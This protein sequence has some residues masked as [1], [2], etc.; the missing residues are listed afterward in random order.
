M[1]IGD[2]RFDTPNLVP[3]EPAGRSEEGGA[4]E[5]NIVDA[6]AKVVAAHPDRLAVVDE[7]AS[8]R[9]DQLNDEAR[10][11]ARFVA[12]L[13]LPAETPVA[14]MI[15]RSWR[16]VAATLGVLMAGCA[17]VPLDP[18]MPLSRRR[19]IAAEAGAPLL[20]SETAQLRD[21][22]RLQWACPDL[23]HILCLDSD[24]LDG[25]SEPHG[26]L[27]SE[28]LWDHL[29]GGAE[30]DVLAGG[31][32]SAFTGQ[33]IPEAAMTAFGANARSKIAPL[34]GS[35][36]SVL[37]IGCASGFTLRAVAPMVTRYLATDL[38]RR[39]IERIV[40]EARRLDL[41][42]V[43]VRVL[44]AHDIDI[45]SDERFDLVIANS[46][47]ESF[48]GFGYLRDF[49]AKA[50]ALLKPGG[51]IFIGHVW[52][53][54]RRD[55]YQDDLAAFARANT[56]LGCQTRL[57]CSED[58][59]IP[60][61]FF[62]DWAAER[63]GI[64][65]IV[66]NMEIDGFDPAPY[67]FD[68]LLRLDP[69]AAQRPPRR[70]RHD[71][72][73]LAATP[74]T[75]LPSP[76][77]RSLAYVLFTSG[78][79]GI[80]KGVMI[81]H[82]S[83]VN[84][85][86]SVNASQFA[87]LGAPLSVACIASFAF[88]GSV[89]QI[90]AALLGGHSLVLPGEEAK[91]D[92]AALH[93]FI[94]SFHLD[95]VD[96]TPSL[97]SM[98]LD[99]WATNGTASSAR[100]FVMGGEVVPSSLPERFFA[101]PAHADATL[102]NAYGP[103]ECCVSAT[104]HV[105]T[106]RTWRETLPP[107]VGRPIRNVIVRICDGA[108]QP[109]PDGVA[110]EILIAGAGVARGYFGMPEATSQRF[111][112]DKANLRWYRS[113]DMGRRLADG[114]LHFL[115]REDG[116]VKVRG[117]RIELSDVEAALTA[118]PFVRHAV[119]LPFDPPDGSGR[120]LAA[121]VVPEAGFDAAACRTDLET[122]LPSF[123]LP[124][125]LVTQDALP[126]TVNGKIDIS[127]LPTPT[128]APRPRPRRPLT[129]D[130]EKVAAIMGKVLGQSIDD[131]DADFFVCGGHSILAVQ[132]VELLRDAFDQTL[133]LSDLFADSTVARLARR[134][135]QRRHDKGL[136]SALVE[137]NDQGA[138]PP[139]VCFHPVGGNVLCYQALAEA[140]GPRQ[141][142][143]MVEA[144]GLERGQS[145]RSS[146]EEMVAAYLPLV[147]QWIGER[148][149]RVAGW[150]FGGLLAVETAYRLDMAGVPVRDVLL[151]DA[152]ASPEPVRQLLARDESDYLAMLFDGLGIADAATLRTLTP[153]QRLDLLVERGQGILPLPDG[154]DRDA[155]RRLL[156]VFQNNALAAIRY[157]PPRLER[158]GAL[159]V[160]PR[161]PSL[162][163]PGIPGDDFNGWH[164]CF[165]QAV[166]LEWMDGN[167]S[168]MLVPP[169]VG[170][171]ANH[172][173]RYLV[174]AITDE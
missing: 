45:L 16:Y 132:L 107:P 115:G 54:D 95:V 40:T 116:Q 94:E 85:A 123:M 19:T 163:A 28:E 7:K 100:L 4:G 5:G 146:V 44:A 56:G 119:V 36:S 33:P 47:V 82:R 171:L 122:R 109:L 161:Q 101:N 34:V 169:H 62:E 63:G 11:V 21:M 172:V 9:Y 168:Q 111:V 134:L 20:I 22:H 170:E 65:A 23:A 166:H 86:E 160:R 112:T 32:K 135:T 137:V 157:C 164:A 104:Q 24:D 75:P 136:R 53:L 77:S 158:L 79:T 26:A 83:V 96:P 43:D 121:Y 151:F 156:A 57:D 98:L 174:R 133:P 99:H 87:G 141:P 129:G 3:N 155:V 80:P 97:F 114:A 148:P 84:L 49:L 143:A 38:S 72:R 149:V 51:A 50:T 12:S 145:L 103:T 14:V 46:V 152:V 37:E 162:Q 81:E 66:S 120:V 110:G 69:S 78:T 6:F 59:F 126:L 118:H 138:E 13:H 68:V 61:A 139:L 88:D 128:R 159:L 10:R 17:F 173:R 153:E 1:K 93:A 131:A 70:W 150:S 165:G 144:Q 167:H 67:G 76:S 106:A 29:S 124:S 147:R 27:M 92:P 18:T 2:I 52:D 90:F 42:Q 35:G 130:E 125:W 15:G 74:A 48:P 25:R 71:R 142:V 102:I 154:I 73:A 64:T 91:H 60:R 108:G 30:D 39:T 58:L 127:R 55:I 89:V 117:N 31:W 8:V 41:P 140:L 105:M 113:G